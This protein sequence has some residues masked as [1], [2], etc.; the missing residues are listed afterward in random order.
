MSP[1]RESLDIQAIT[2]DNVSAAHRHSSFTFHPVLSAINLHKATGT[3]H[4]RLHSLSTGGF[5]YRLPR[6]TCIHPLTHTTRGP[7]FSQIE[8]DLVLVLQQL[9]AS[10]P[11]LV[12]A[13]LVG[14]TQVL[15]F[16]RKEE[17]LP[18]ALI[19]RY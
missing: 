5:R 14:M 7:L 15:A 2:A 1:H 10:L 3:S 6:T 19:Q 12:L 16:P 18:S 11:L 9:H 8:Q 13:L 17:R 4:R